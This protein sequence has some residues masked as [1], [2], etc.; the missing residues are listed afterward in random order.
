M[1]CRYNKIRIDVKV[2]MSELIRIMTLIV[3]ICVATSSFSKASLLFQYQYIY[4]RFCEEF[5]VPF[6]ENSTVQNSTDLDFRRHE[7]Q[8]SS[9][10]YLMYLSLTDSLTGMIISFPIGS[11]SDRIGRKP[12]FYLAIISIFMQVVLNSNGIHHS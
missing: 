4:Y 7:A 5:N 1:K 6:W 11:L 8:A 9:A 12:I 2:E 3:C 10:Q